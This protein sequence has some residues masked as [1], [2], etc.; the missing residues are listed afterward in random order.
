MSSSVIETLGITR[1]AGRIV[2]LTL[3]VLLITK[4]SKT[5]I[6]QYNFCLLFIQKTHIFV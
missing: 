6:V 4:K 2:H 5:Y 1:Y 3:T